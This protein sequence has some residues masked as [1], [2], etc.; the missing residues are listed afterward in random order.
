MYMHTCIGG[1]RYAVLFTE[2]NQSG[3]VNEDQI[4]PVPAPRRGA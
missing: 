4:K 1:G 2:Y 3:D